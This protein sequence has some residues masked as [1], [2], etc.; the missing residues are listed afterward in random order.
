MTHKFCYL[1]R[2]LDHTERFCTKLFTM[3][4]ADLKREGSLNLRA[5]MRRNTSGGGERWLRE[6]GSTSQENAYYNMGKE[7]PNMS[8]T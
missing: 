4:N 8:L 7:S 5:M 1:C 3:E 6:Q 2:L